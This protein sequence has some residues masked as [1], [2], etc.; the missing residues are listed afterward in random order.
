M[1]F[2]LLTR[3]LLHVQRSNKNT[4]LINFVPMPPLFLCFPAY[5]SHSTQINLV[6]ISDF[7]HAIA[8]VKLTSSSSAPYSL[9]AALSA[10]LLLLADVGSVSSSSSLSSARRVKLG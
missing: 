4:R 1:E 10:S 9:S 5:S 8:S 2:L 3:I 7:E 6:F